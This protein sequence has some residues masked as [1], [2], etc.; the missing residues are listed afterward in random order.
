[1]SQETEFEG[2]ICSMHRQPISLCPSDC[3]TKMSLQKEEEEVIEELPKSHRFS[4][5]VTEREEL[6]RILNSYPG[7]HLIGVTDSVFFGNPRLQ[8][9]TELKAELEAYKQT[10]P[11][12]WLPPFAI[13]DENPDPTFV[14]DFHDY[15][16]EKG[17][18]AFDN[19]RE[20]VM[21]YNKE[22]LKDYSD[23]QKLLIC[24]HPQTY[25]QTEVV[26][27]K[28]A[29]RR[30]NETIEDSGR[31][32]SSV[33]R[34]WIFSDQPE[35]YLAEQEKFLNKIRAEELEKLEGHQAD[36]IAWYIEGA[37][38]LRDAIPHKTTVNGARQKI[39]A[40][41]LQNFMDLKVSGWSIFPEVVSVGDPDFDGELFLQ[42]RGLKRLGAPGSVET[43]LQDLQAY[44]T[45]QTKLLKELHSL[46]DGE[47]VTLITEKTNE[48]ITISVIQAR[49][50]VQQYPLPDFQGKGKLSLM[51]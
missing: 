28:E 1:M 9:V 6:D 42:A 22:L 46:S 44:V 8:S 43:I 4:K 25:G 14:D 2:V 11:S 13:I 32:Y 36:E 48:P 26:T 7:D 10:E 5:E 40:F 41:T 29:R 50:Y 34:I 20:D 27:V 24:F 18:K 12:F 19:E 31:V 17:Q 47:I 15:L 23:D 33:D 49:E 16:E 37:D 30:A 35:S 39:F 45:F 3:P 21:A 51:K 38:K